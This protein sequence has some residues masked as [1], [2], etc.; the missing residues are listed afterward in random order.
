MKRTSSLVHGATLRALLFFELDRKGDM[1][2]FS[3]KSNMVDMEIRIPGQ[4]DCA[5][6]AANI[7]VSALINPF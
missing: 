5:Q 2:E 7:A 4:Q 1:A 3:S 6:Q